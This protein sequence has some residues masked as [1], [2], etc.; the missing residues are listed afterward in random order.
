VLA[1]VLVP[2]SRGDV[3]D[4]LDKAVALVNAKRGGEARPVFEA[5]LKAGQA[6]PQQ[7]QRRGGEAPASLLHVPERFQPVEM[8]PVQLGPRR[9]AA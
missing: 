5:V 2:W 1:P 7:C 3:K 4:D 8:V 6:T 9:V